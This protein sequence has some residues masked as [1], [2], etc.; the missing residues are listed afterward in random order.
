M[1]QFKLNNVK[2]E[3]LDGTMTIN[4]SYSTKENKKKPAI[5][6]SYDVKGLD[7]QKTFYAFNTVQ[8]L[9][10]VGKYIEWQITS[11]LPSPVIW[12]KICIPISTRSVAMEICY[13]SKAC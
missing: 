12:E 13:Y 6:L 5:A 4:G 1:K 10:P 2:A 8:K 9:M 11:Q 3:A 7:V